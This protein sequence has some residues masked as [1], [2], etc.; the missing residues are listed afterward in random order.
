[1]AG[2]I[3]LEVTQSPL[4]AVDGSPRPHGGTASTPS[5]PTAACSPIPRTEDDITHLAEPFDVPLPLAVR[6][7]RD[8]LAEY[9]GPDRSILLLDE[10]TP[11]ADLVPGLNATVDPAVDVC[12]LSDDPASP[13]AVDAT[14]PRRAS[15]S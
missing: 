4:V 7:V 11:G 1:M 8:H 15:R 12:D 3:P 10:P 2:R 9:Y 6:W 13:G 5:A 14:S